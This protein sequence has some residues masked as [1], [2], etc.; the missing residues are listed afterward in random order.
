MDITAIYPG[1]FDP[2]TLG[3]IDVATRASRMFD[4]VVIAVAESPGKQPHF[5]LE[6]RSGFVADALAD[7][8][9]IR[10]QS[11]CGL[12]VDVASEIDATVIV[13][14][15]RAVSDFEYEV[16]LANLN[17]Q[18][19]PEI[20]TVFVAAASQYTFVSS[21]IVREIAKLGGDVSRF[22]NP[23]VELALR[24]TRARDV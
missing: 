18:L 4:N 19:N 22:V 7:L 6:T 9:N 21:S 17:R 24:E 2:V 13:R 1:T 11:F 8:S 20:E 16:Q 12:L 14:G 23:A 15:L 5:D 10:V 3:H